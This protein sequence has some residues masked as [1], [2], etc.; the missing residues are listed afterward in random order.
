[1]NA[2]WTA[3]DEIELQEWMKKERLGIFYHETKWGI[4]KTGRKPVYWF[5]NI[6]EMK[7]FLIKKML[8]SKKR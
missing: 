7:L 8:E 2:H 5:T 3:N 1:M 6:E 4:A